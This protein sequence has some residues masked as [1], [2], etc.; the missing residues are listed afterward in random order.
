MTVDLIL[1]LN[2]P[3]CHVCLSL[4]LC[5]CVCA[6]DRHLQKESHIAEYRKLA[7]LVLEFIGGARLQDEMD[8]LK[9]FGHDDIVEYFCKV[10]ECQLMHQIH[11]HCLTAI[12]S[13]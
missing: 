10:L 9:R 6:S 8:I 5:V 2:L 3:V 13:L 11:L 7:Q 4:S 1:F 12:E